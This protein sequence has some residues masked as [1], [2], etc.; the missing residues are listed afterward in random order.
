MNDTPDYIV[1]FAGGLADG[2]CLFEPGVVPPV[3][4]MGGKRRLAPVILAALGLRPGQGA[5]RVVAV[6]AAPWGWVWPAILHPETSRAVGAVLR[7]WREGPIQD[8]WFRLR[9]EGPREDPVEAVA[10]WLVLQA[11]SANGA[12]VF[13][14]SKQR[15]QTRSEGRD[16][17]AYVM[18]CGGAHAQLRQGSGAGRKPQPAGQRDPQQ[19]DP[20]LMASDGRGV[21][22]EAGIK[23]DKSCLRRGHDDG[24]D[25]P[26]DQK[27]V[28]RA[29]CGGLVRIETLAERVEAIGRAP[30]A[31]R[32]Q[33]IHGRAED[34][35]A[36]L[37]GDLRGSAVY[38]DPPLPR[39]H[40]LRVGRRAQRPRGHGPGVRPARS[41]GGDLRG[42]RVGVGARPGVGGAGRH[43][44][45]EGGVADD[46]ARVS[47]A[48]ARGA[49][50][51]AF[52]PVRSEESM[53]PIENVVAWTLPAHPGPPPGPIHQTLHGYRDGHQ[54]LATSIPLEPGEKRVLDQ[55]SDL[56]G[57]LPPGLDFDVYH[58]A[59]P[60][61]RFY[62]L[63][64]TWP[65]RSGTRGGTVLTHT[66]L[67]PPSVAGDIPDP[68]TLGHLWRCP[69]SVA[70]APSYGAALDLPV[71]GT[72][73]APPAPSPAEDAALWALFF[74]QPERPILW[75]EPRPER[76]AERIRILWAG[77]PPEYRSDLA[78]CTL[79]L[80]MR[81]VGGR[82]F[83]VFI[84]PPAC[85]G[86]YRDH[87]Q[88]TG[89]WLGDRIDD[90]TRALTER[91]QLRGLLERGAEEI[92]ALRQTCRMY[93]L[94]LP[95]VAQLPRL[96][97][98][99]D[100]ETARHERPTAAAGADFLRGLLWP[101]KST[102]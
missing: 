23:G 66:L 97:R 41:A 92:E 59:F 1:P 60:C 22:R 4:W 99:L 11:R 62:A 19:T 68:F 49:V 65:D 61:G 67:V 90:A 48:D 89:W 77:L 55:L 98:W 86:A 83:D 18:Q 85:R 21:V 6:D 27:G 74:T 2:L 76:G 82:P 102:P 54:L 10:Q 16:P 100:M 75:L 32:I 20:K 44:R 81:R 31:S 69:S 38:L 57:Y 47:P 95:S 9:D 78:F 33:V 25:R 52:T 3:S 64:A 7:A 63:S 79:A 45:E 35:P 39:L 43:Y 51:L 24:G 101:P 34:L 37:P 87:L 26:A 15:H 56:S 8:L 40:R 58:S 93:G 13:W 29:G 28:N 36:Q 53:T 91:P 46:M 50:V 72:A 5:R 84:V 14:S 12:P 80:Q 70:E 17:D 30:W 96:L 94:P 71:E 42:G 88:R 73:P